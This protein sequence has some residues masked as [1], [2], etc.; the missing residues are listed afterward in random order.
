ML[1]R[2]MLPPDDPHYMLAIGNLA[3]AF[4]NCGRFDEA[5]LV[6]EVNSLADCVQM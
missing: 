6:S 1:L 4:S 3:L 5:L 2:R